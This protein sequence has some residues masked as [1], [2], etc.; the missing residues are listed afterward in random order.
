LALC[1]AWLRCPG[2]FACPSVL[3]GSPIR[4]VEVAEHRECAHVARTSRLYVIPLEPIAL[5]HEFSPVVGANR[6]GRGAVATRSRGRSRSEG[7]PSQDAVA[8]EHGGDAALDHD[9]DRLARVRPPDRALVPAELDIA[10]PVE[11]ADADLAVGRRGE[12]DPLGAQQGQVQSARRTGSGGV[13]RC[14][15]YESA[16]ALG[17]LGHTRYHY[18]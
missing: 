14:G 6:H 11:A 7:D 9:G 17:I 5:W 13:P 16:S 4:V 2:R 8:V 12:V 10:A 15:Y 3:R 1:L 18:P